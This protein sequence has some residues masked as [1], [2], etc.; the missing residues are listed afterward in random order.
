MFRR[1]AEAVDAA[2]REEDVALQKWMR[3]NTEGFEHALAVVAEDGRWTATRTFVVR[4][5]VLQP[6]EVPAFLTREAELERETGRAVE[7]ERVE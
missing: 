6:A 2:R 4:G 5:A 7:L 3:D 1:T